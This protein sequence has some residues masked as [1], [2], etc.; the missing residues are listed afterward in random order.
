MSV[1]PAVEGGVDGGD[2]P[3]LVRA[4]LDGQRHGA[5]ADGADGG[6]GDGA[7]LHGGSLPQAEGEGSM[8][9]ASETAPGS[10]SVVR[11]KE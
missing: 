4:V 11:E 2:G 10:Q 6:A 9:R 8:V 7:V 5:Q 1:T 3:R